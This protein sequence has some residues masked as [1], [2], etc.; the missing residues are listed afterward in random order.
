MVS[1]LY[2]RYSLI[3]QIT[4]L[5]K[6]SIYAIFVL[7]IA[8]KP[9]SSLNMDMATSAQD[10][11][12][13]IVIVQIDRSI[14]SKHPKF[15]WEYSINYGF[16]PG[17]LSSDGEELDAYVIGIDKPVE[18]FEGMCI[19]VIHRTNDD[20]DKLIVV[21]EDK[22]GMTDEEIRKATDFQERYFASEIIR[23]M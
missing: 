21:P 13:K 4:K 7:E 22:K 15:G 8:F 18:F 16:V 14:G 1:Y 23:S 19:A 10:F 2:F 3:K 17:T 12:G 5:S 6:P 11:L 20:D 9:I